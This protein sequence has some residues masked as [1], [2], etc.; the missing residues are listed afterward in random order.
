MCSKHRCINPL[1]IEYDKFNPLRM[2]TQA[3][4]GLVDARTKGLTVTEECLFNAYRFAEE[5]HLQM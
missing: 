4:L 5:R 1:T 3:L 2:Q